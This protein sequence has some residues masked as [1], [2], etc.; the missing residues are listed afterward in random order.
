M[1]WAYAMAR[2]DVGRVTLSLYLVPA[3]AIVIALAWLGQVPGPAELGGGAIALAGVLGAS[4][5][6]RRPALPP[7]APA[8]EPLARAD[9]V[10]PI[11][12]GR[13]WNQSR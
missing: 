5:R 9:V 7:Q 10:E 1:L 4:S 2:L 12:L 6:P 13:K 3:A 8:P 11:S